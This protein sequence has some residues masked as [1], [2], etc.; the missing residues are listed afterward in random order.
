LLL[1]SVCI[2]LQDLRSLGAFAKRQNATVTII[3][4][5]R[6]HGT[7]RR[8]L[9]GF[10][11]HFLFENFSKTCLE[12]S[13][14]VKIWREYRVLYMRTDRLYICDHILLYLQID[15]LYICDHISL[16]SA[17]NDKCLAQNL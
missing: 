6:P 17:W 7:T 10:S 16:D 1:V 11:W 4:S 2:Y 14:L 13:S 5:V 12:N 3:M 15:I 8:P 9:D